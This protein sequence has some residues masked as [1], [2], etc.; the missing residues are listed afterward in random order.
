MNQLPHFFPP[1]HATLTKIS[2][3]EN[4]WQPST[5]FN[6]GH[7]TSDTSIRKSDKAKIPRDKTVQC[8]EQRG[9]AIQGYPA[10]TFV[11][12]LWTQRYGTGGHYANHYDWATASKESRRVSTFMVYLAANCTGGGTNFPRIRLPSSA[13]G[14][15]GG[16]CEFVE[17]GES[18]VE[19]VTFRP[20]A[21]N[22]VFW[23]NFDPEGRGYKETIHAGMPVLSG[24]KIGLNLWSWYQAGYSAAD[25]AKDEL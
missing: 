3:S 14:G 21:G 10:S 1:Q 2:P 7:E 4:S 24:T 18:D 15:E 17:C 5:I 11:E 23:L 8:I 6:A 13:G 25:L 19:G 20:V 9:L 22:A 12:R 16:W